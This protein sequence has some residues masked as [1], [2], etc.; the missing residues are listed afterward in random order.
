MG[1]VHPRALWYYFP[2]LLTIKLSLGV[3]LLAMMLLLLQP[4]SLLNWAVLA[5]LVLLCFSFTFRVQIGIRMI[6]PLVT[7]GL[8]GL[9]GA[10]VHT[11]RSWGYQWRS[12]SLV[13]S[14]AAALV[15][16]VITAV[17]V[18]PHGLCY[19]NELWGNTAQG[20]LYV[21]DSNYDWGQ[22]MK[23]LAQWQ[24][25]HQVD[26]LDLWYFGL[27][28]NAD[29]LPGRRLAP[30]FVQQ[31]QLPSRFQPAMRGRFLAVSLTLL[32]GSYTPHLP[33]LITFLRSRP[34]VA[35]TQ[36]FFI[37]DFTDS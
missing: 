23:E 10:V 34:P 3:M 1:E 22:G 2:V 35:R 8:V 26:N 7:L 5:S 21:S 25:D 14:T 19:T 33:D 29:T 32:Y 37:Y 20:Y 16:L 17:N 36:T 9:A 4:K 13:G 6:L 18:W 11:C 31:N 12:F 15:W 28:P 27:D 24:R 30:D